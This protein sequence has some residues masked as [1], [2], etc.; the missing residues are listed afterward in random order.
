[1]K[2]TIVGITTREEF[3]NDAGRVYPASATFYVIRKNGGDNSIGKKGDEIKL[4]CT[5]EVYQELLLGTNTLEHA[6]HA[7][8]DYSY[9]ATSYGKKLEDI[10]LIS[11]VNKDGEVIDYKEGDDGPA[12]FDKKAPVKA[13]A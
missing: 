2:G 12:L 10:T 11:Y 8:V 1:M 13:S 7:V 5:H 3:K 4:P 6:L 9:E